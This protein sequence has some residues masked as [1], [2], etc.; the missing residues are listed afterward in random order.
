MSDLIIR[1]GGLRAVAALVAKSLLVV[2][3][4][5]IVPLVVLDP[6][7]AIRTPAVE[8]HD[9]ADVLGDAEL[10]TVL[11]GI[12]FREDIRLAVLTLDGIDPHATSDT[13]F[14]DAV[15]DYALDQQPSWIST[16]G[17]HWA[18]GLVI[19]AVSPHGRW[20]GCYFGEDVKVDYHTQENIQNA[21]KN[22]FR[23]WRWNDGMEAMA[24]RTAES[25]GRPIVSTEMT[26]FAAILGIAAASALL[27]WMLWSRR[28]ARES[29]RRARRHFTRITADYDA[30]QIRAGTIPTDDAYGA[31]VLARFRWFENG[32]F[33]LVEQFRD[34]GSPRAAQWFAGGLRRSARAMETSAKELDQVDD[35]IAAASTFLTR[36]VGW[37]KA[38]ENEQGPVH[39]DLA[40]YSK[41]CATVATS[42]RASGVSFDVGPDRAWIQDRRDRLAAMT[43]ELFLRKLTPSAALH[44]LDTIA[45]D[46]R[47]RCESLAW[48]A[49]EADTSR[50]GRDRLTRYEYD[51][52]RGAYRSDNL[53]YRGWWSSSSR[54][55]RVHYNPAATIRIN[56]KSPGLRALGARSTSAGAV[57]RFSRPVANLVTGY[58]KAATYTPS[59]SS[60]GGFSGSGSSSHFSGGHHSGGGSFRGSGSSS[61][62]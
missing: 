47:H 58:S 2:V 35:V 3:L 44:E 24:R 1:W 30:T 49:L 13:V 55:G 57:P 38:W 34:F 62:F 5:A 11:E 53:D 10:Q 6:F 20:V 43:V 50:L 8:I 15:L 25:L 21:A 54:S 60:G 61:R 40:S 42:T 7:G 27:T 26:A 29:Y 41:L 59:S 17:R 28:E 22:S 36:G 37:E 56:S 32:Y 16:D 46:V 52:A 31:Q 45:A 23:A 51:D 33:K 19:L 14:N 12:G 48:R 39:E 4:G 18:D 9:E